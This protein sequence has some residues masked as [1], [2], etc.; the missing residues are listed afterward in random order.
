MN[1]LKKKKKIVIIILYKLPISFWNVT[2]TLS[3]LVN[4]S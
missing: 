1:L 2:C 3:K 4:Y